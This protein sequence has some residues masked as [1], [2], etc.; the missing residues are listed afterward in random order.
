M[1]NS[2]NFH[3]CILQNM[4][5]CLN[6]KSNEI[7]DILEVKLKVVVVVNYKNPLEIKLFPYLETP[8]TF[9]LI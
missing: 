2:V 3:S 1:Q 4:L 6:Q 7:S 9:Y 5:M 8:H